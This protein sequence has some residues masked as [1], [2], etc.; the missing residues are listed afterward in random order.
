MGEKNANSIFLQ[1]VE[2]HEVIDEIADINIKKAMGYDEIPPKV[3]KW[4]PHVFVPILCKLF[5]KM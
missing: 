4:A 1:E 2:L 5:N 3:I